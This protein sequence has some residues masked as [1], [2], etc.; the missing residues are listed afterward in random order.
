M[1]ALALRNRRLWLLDAYG[2]ALTARQQEAL[3]LH[4]AED[5][6]LTELARVLGTSRAAAHDLVRRGTEHL[7][8]LEAQLGLAQRLARAERAKERLQLRLRRLERSANSAPVG[9]I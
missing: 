9:V 5:W 7:E 3:R 1:T 8:E 6:S 2:A 4:L